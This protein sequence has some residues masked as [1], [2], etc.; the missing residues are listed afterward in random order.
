[1]QR[2]NIGRLEDYPESRGTL[3]QVGGRRVAV[4]R[5]DMQLFAI[6]DTC[7]HRRFPL[8]DGSLN[9]LSVSCRTHGSCFD[10]ISGAVLRGPAR[11]PVPVY[12]AHVVD[13]Q[14]TLELPD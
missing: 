5:I 14:V 6:E 8:H 2:I 1:M 10:L 4:F 3:V 11:K 7:P 9:G 12:R 13:D